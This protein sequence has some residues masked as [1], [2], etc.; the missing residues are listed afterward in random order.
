MHKRCSEGSNQRGLIKHPKAVT[1]LHLISLLARCL[2]VPVV[3]SGAARFPLWSRTWRDLQ[4]RSLQTDCCGCC[5]L[6]F[7]STRISCA[8]SALLVRR[9]SW[10]ELML[11]APPFDEINLTVIPSRRWHFSAL[12]AGVEQ[13]KVFIERVQDGQTEWINDEEVGGGDAK[14]QTYVTNWVQRGTLSSPR[15]YRLTLPVLVQSPDQSGEKESYISSEISSGPVLFVI[16][17][18]DSK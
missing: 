13:L 16:M 18:Y 1:L 11:L 7:M 4:L 10:W 15:H 9:R 8:M 12:T 3:V 6:L 14:G 2:C 5:W 17:S